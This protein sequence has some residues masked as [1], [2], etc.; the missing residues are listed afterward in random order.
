MART[1][2]YAAADKAIRAFTKA[3]VGLLDAAKALRT[4]VKQKQEQA[5]RLTVEIDQMKRAAAKCWRI[6][7]NIDKL[8][9]GGVV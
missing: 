5:A 7:A 8:T 6:T 4:E 3:K 9:E 2:P 1:N